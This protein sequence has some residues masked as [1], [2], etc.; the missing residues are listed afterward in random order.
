MDDD[1]NNYIYLKT[2][3]QDKR[4][5]EM[6]EINNDYTKQDLLSYIIDNIKF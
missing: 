5:N 6:Y 4:N 3:P 2:I 1:L